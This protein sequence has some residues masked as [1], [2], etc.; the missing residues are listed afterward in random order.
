M[1][2]SRVLL[3]LLLLLRDADGNST[4][5]R[6]SYTPDHPTLPGPSRWYEVALECAGAAQSPITI[7]VGGYVPEEGFM[8]VWVP[9]KLSGDMKVSKQ[10]TAVAIDVRE[11]GVQL[12]TSFLTEVYALHEIVLHTMAEHVLGSHH[13]HIEMQL[14]FHPADLPYLSL[15]ARDRASKVVVSLIYNAAADSGYPVEDNPFLGYIFETVATASI[16]ANTTHTFPWDTAT[17]M[18]FRTPLGVDFLNERTSYYEYDGSDT[19][20]PCKEVVHW[21]ISTDVRKVPSSVLVGLENALDSAAGNNRP[22]Q[23]RGGRKISYRRYHT[24]VHPLDQSEFTELR[25]VSSSF[26]GSV[27]HSGSVQIA[28]DDDSHTTLVLVVILVLLAVAL[29]GVC[30]CIVLMLMKKDGYRS[31]EEEMKTEYE[32]EEVEEEEE[33]EGE[34]EEGEEEEGEEVGD[35]EV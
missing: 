6:F 29:I 35:P 8:H 1:T 27:P 3:L 30:A 2:G 5:L 16:A 22:V 7:P 13:H 31:W 24:S 15:D 4:G 34:E 18:D 9:W 32:E 14:V 12:V 28:T 10:G 23:F 20:P 19:T 33:E 25:V 26:N 17:G 21:M 11:R